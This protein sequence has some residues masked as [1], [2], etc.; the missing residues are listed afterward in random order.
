MRTAVFSAALAL[1]SAVQADPREFTL[2][3]GLRLIVKEDHR[4][5]TAVHQVWYR[6]GSMEETPG[7]T[8]VAHVL[9]HMMFKGTRRVGPEEFSRLVAEAGG[10]ENAFTSTDYTVYHEQVHRD[11]LPLVM[12][13]EADR[14][15]NL[16]V[17]P[18]EFAREIKVVMEERRWRYEDKPRSLLEENLMATAF[19]AHPYKWPVIGWMQ[20]LQNMSWKDASAWYR[21]WYSPNNAT[22]IVVGDVEPE[23]VLAWARRYYGALVPRANL[24]RKPFSEPAQRGI[25]YVTVKAPA[26]LAYVRLGYK[27]PVL[28]D[29]ANDWEPFAISLL[30]QLLGGDDAA[31][32]NQILVRERRIA[33]SAEAEY[34]LISRGPGMVFL[35]AAAA[36]GHSGVELESALREIV[37]RVA[38]GGVTPEELERAKVQRLAQI[39]YRR[40]SFFAQAL[41]LGELESSG[42]SFRDADRIPDRL[43]AITVEQIQAAAAKYLIDDG[44]T[45]AVLD[46]QPLKPGPPGVAAPAIRH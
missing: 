16:V 29:P 21:R 36:E 22:V 37:A 43:K 35:E 18:E 46:P 41:E 3:N 25:K 6:V 27:A 26:E 31:R 11:R 45:V 30:A 38:A 4:A 2:P 8:G 15:A 5:P 1:A 24:A 42:L 34:E 23:R 32:L 17:R 12:Q 28:R 13:L 39:V 40:D 7:T 33:T 19:A 20:D 44:L 9:E 10:R 14:M